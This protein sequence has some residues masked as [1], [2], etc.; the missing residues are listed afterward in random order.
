MDPPASRTLRRKRCPESSP[1]L[2]ISCSHV[3]AYDDGLKGTKKGKCCQL[4]ALLLSLL[5]TLQLKSLLSATRRRRRLLH[6][7]LTQR[8]RRQCT[9]PLVLPNIHNKHR[10][11]HPLACTLFHGAGTTLLAARTVCKQKDQQPHALEA[12]CALQKPRTLGSV[13]CVMFAGRCMDLVLPPSVT[14][15]FPFSLSKGVSLQRR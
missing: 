3:R 1:C 13:A 15:S 6:K 8:G 10:G 12:C 4:H 11:L 2:H 14:I 5:T 7:P 9:Q